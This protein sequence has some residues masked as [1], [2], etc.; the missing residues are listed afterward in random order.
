ML[1]ENL[2]LFIFFLSPAL[3]RRRFDFYYR[4]LARLNSDFENRFANNINLQ[5]LP[6][7]SA[8]AHIADNNFSE[9]KG[10]FDVIIF[11]SEG[12][13]RVEGY[14]DFDGSAYGFANALSELNTPYCYDRK[15]GADAVLK[16]LGEP[17]LTWLTDEFSE[18]VSVGGPNA[19]RI[20]ANADLSSYRYI[21]VCFGYT[22]AGISLDGG[23][24]S[25]NCTVYAYNAARALGVAILQNVQNGATIDFQ[26]AA[27]TG[28]GNRIVWGIQ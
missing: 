1:S 22:N 26:H 3:S 18:P 24:A 25:S 17:A 2:I 9:Y 6:L 16:K 11:A 12:W 5:S 14:R 21:I 27:G 4:Y 19:H 20:T 23:Y 7:K 15:A 13:F 8:I 10:S 28:S